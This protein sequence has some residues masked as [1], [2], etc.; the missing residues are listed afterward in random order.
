MLA[1]VIR[2]QALWKGRQLRVSFLSLRAAACTIQVGHTHAQLIVDFYG[3]W[4]LWVGVGGRP[5]L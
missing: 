5:V 3:C 1:A 2:L 4:L